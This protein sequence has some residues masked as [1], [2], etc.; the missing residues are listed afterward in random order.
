MK[1]GRHFPCII[2]LS[3]GNSVPLLV[4][5]KVSHS[6]IRQSGSRLI[7][8]AASHFC[9]SYFT[10]TSCFSGA[11]RFPVLPLA[12]AH[13]AWALVLTLICHSRSEGRG[14]GGRQRGSLLWSDSYKILIGTR[15]M[16]GREK[17]WAER[18][19]KRVGGSKGKISHELMFPSAP[20]F[21]L[22]PPVWF[23]LPP[24]FLL[25]VSPL[26]WSPDRV[27]YRS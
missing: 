7:C 23:P 2:S 18:G 19:K 21:F 26:R 25:L 13:F 27:N 11:K 15:N 22:P 9:L 1:I 17:G 3:V 20:L 16:I 24:F 14:W 5:Y 4:I 6:C 10:A 8:R 12:A